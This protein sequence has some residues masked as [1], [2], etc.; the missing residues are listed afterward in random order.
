MVSGESTGGR[1]TR[2]KA[3]DGDIV[4]QA[5]ELTGTPEEGGRLA[6][7]TQQQTRRKTACLAA[8]C[9]GKKT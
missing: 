5:T 1:Q 3:S 8:P 9:R 7:S 6:L 4:A 2:I